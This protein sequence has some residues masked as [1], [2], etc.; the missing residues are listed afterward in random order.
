[1][2]IYNKRV[3]INMRKPFADGNTGEE[4]QMGLC[5]VDP[6]EQGLSGSDGCGRREWKNLWGQDPGMHEW[7]G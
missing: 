4:R 1:M 2:Y 6:K 3:G 5:H 7:Q